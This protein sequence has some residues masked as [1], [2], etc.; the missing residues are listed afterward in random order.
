MLLKDI[1]IHWGFQNMS[2]QNYFRKISEALC[3]VSKI[4]RRD[5]VTT[6]L[7]SKTGF[8]KP[9]AETQRTQRNCLR[10][11][12]AHIKKR[13]NVIITNINAFFSRWLLAISHWLG[14]LAVEPKKFKSLSSKAKSLS[15]NQPL[16]SNLEKRSKLL[17]LQL[18]RL[19]L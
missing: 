6:T 1:I 7:N 15:L 12:Q 14:L 4:S 17:L 16:I 5:S 19:P 18:E 8:R 13:I 11:A 9:L 3:Q 2:C 10:Q